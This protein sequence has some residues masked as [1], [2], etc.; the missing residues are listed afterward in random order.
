MLK[1]QIIPF[2][3]NAAGVKRIDHCACRA[4]A[5]RADKPLNVP[6]FILTVQTNELIPYYQTCTF[7]QNLTNA[8]HHTPKDETI[9]LQGISGSLDALLIAAV[10]QHTT[11]LQCIVLEDQAAAW[12]LYG[13]CCSLLSAHKVFLLPGMGSNRSEHNQA[14]QH[15]RMEIVH[16]LTKPDRVA[17]LV[18]HLEALMDKVTDP[19]LDRAQHQHLEVGQAFS[20]SDFVALLTEQRFSKVDF[21]CA[22][23]QFALRG[24]IVDVY[25]AS[26]A[27]PYRI[28]LW[29]DTVSSIR[30]FDPKDQKSFQK[31]TTATI[32]PYRMMAAVPPT[33]SV[34]VAACLPPATTLWFRNKQKA[35]DRLEPLCTDA[36]CS[37]QQPSYE[38]LTSVLASWVP[39][40]Q[41][42]WGTEQSSASGPI[43]IY[44]SEA[45][46]VFRQNFDRLAEDLAQRNQAGYRTFVSAVAVGQLTR[47]HAVLD[48][49]PNKPTFEPL[50]LGL[51]EG[52][53]DHN[54]KLLCYTDHQIF[55]R[56]YRYQPPKRI[57]QTEA[58]LIQE[59]K[60]LHLGDYVV[61]RDHGI[62][63]FSGLHIL[64][65]NGSKQE[66]IRLVYRNNDT[67]FVNVNELYKI[68]KYTS[69]EGAPPTLN[70][71]GT[72]AWQHKKSAIKKQIKEM[73]QELLTLYA[74]RK[75]KMGF[76]FSSDTALDAALAASFCYEETP[77]Q[78]AAIA[79]VKA[80]M[81]RPYP[82]DRLVC[83]DVG[84]GKTEIAIRAAF[85]AAADGKQVAVLVPTTILALQHY[86]SFVERLADLPVQ[87]SYLNRFKSKQEVQQTLAKTASGM[88]DIL[89]GTHK[90]LTPS[91]QFKDLGLLIV[92][93]EQK[94]GVRAKEALRKWRVAVDTLTLTA[95]PIPRT[96]HFSLMGARDLSLLTTPPA[97]RRPVQTSLHVWDRSLLQTAIQTELD[98]GGQVFFVHNRVSS[99][100]SIAQ[101]LSEYVPTARICVAHGQMTGATLEEK[102]LQ[103]VAGRYDV[104]VATSI[105][106]SGLDIPNANTIL[107]NDSHLLGL[108]DLHQMRGRVGRSN[109]QAFC[110]LL[111]PEN[112]PLTPEAKLRLAALEEFSDLGEGFNL[113]MR[114]LDIR[115]A[116]DLLGASQSG[117]IA[118]IGFETYCRLLEEAVEE[119]KCE[120]Q[121]PFPDDNK[122][123]TVEDCIVETDCEA[124]L[125]P[126]YISHMGQR[127]ALYGRLNQ[128][129]NDQ[130]L[131]GFREELVDRF[132]PLPPAAETLLETVRLRWE[133]QRIG[134]TKLTFNHQAL[135]CHL[136]KDFLQK[137]PEMWQQL[138]QYMKDNPINCQ[139]KNMES[140]FVLTLT[141]PFL[142]PTAVRTCLAGIGV[143]MA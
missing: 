23:G 49:K 51:R 81:E 130:Q 77:D 22:P 143:G 62:G 131:L 4:A 95:T 113:A 26:E 89:I 76:A 127:M 107:I 35:L 31:T 128:V 92:D 75:K 135:R 38:P 28:E 55:N 54:A 115:G 70:T 78:A 140:H 53:I 117:F 15:K 65:A 36:D 83:G 32:V 46:P 134:F 103:F 5:Y 58:L 93:E 142:N 66:A 112:A 119:A 40:R 12:A 2:C 99:I 10:Q 84:F 109:T 63:R 121:E 67:V 6:L 102:M 98:R 100:Q 8:L 59:V 48:E 126:E 25:T 37:I 14:V 86:H 42:E 56:Y 111:I 139:F 137:N 13:D 94:F 132:G 85:K 82:M 41:I 61:H 21:V 50:L 120:A 114:D 1:K 106:E 122:A 17:V 101:L 69:K 3:R 73:A 34:S 91:V 27:F 88:V 64:Q 110:Y 96:L 52:F 33:A 68:S 116:G 18:T 24:G 129:K 7:V 16:A 141:G 9:H 44:H 47:L 108:S 11:Q 43:Q 45:Q 125:P 57:G 105:I 124:L 79:A 60:N 29:G 138:V 133:A 136:G 87:V 20:L 71:L 90:L 19:I 39:F 80:D 104:L 72:A 30:L 123:K 97:N 74:A 118:D